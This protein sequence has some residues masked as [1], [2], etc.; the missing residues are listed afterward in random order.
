MKNVK[1]SDEL[2]LICLKIIKKIPSISM[3]QLN[4]KLYFI[5]AAFMVEFSREAFPDDFYAWGYGPA[6]KSLCE[7]FRN[8]ETLKEHLKDFNLNSKLD[9]TLDE[10]IDLIIEEFISDTSKELAIRTM[11]YDS[12]KNNFICTYKKI[13]KDDIVK[14]HLK[15]KKETGR[16]F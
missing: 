7:E 15:I 6:L 11:S 4:K 1:T 3:L 2:K 13:S 8:I 14:C 12:W 10:L 9:Q 5:Q 16:L